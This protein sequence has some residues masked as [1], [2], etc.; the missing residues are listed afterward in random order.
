MKDVLTD[1]SA[2]CGV[3][4]FNLDGLASQLTYLISHYITCARAEKTDVVELDIG[5][6][7]LILKLDD[8]EVKYKF[9]PSNQLSKE[10]IN[11]YNSKDSVL[12]QKADKLIGQ[13]I[14]KTYRELL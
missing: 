14:N 10:V 3:K 12:I 13:R 2:L 6:G 7:T 8:I 4:R 1:L 5:I 11:G 9:I